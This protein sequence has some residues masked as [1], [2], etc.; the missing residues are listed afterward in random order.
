MVSRLPISTH[1][2]PP[3]AHRVHPQVCIL[4]SLYNSIIIT[5]SLSYLSNSFRYPLPWD[6]CPLVRNINVTGE[7]REGEA[8]Q[9]QGRQGNQAARDRE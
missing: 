7:E 1:P 6:K 5:G 4:V 2:A 9:S 3:Q 8:Q